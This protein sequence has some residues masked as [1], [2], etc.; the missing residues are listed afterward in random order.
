MSSVGTAIFYSR[1]RYRATFEL[2]AVFR[3][4]LRCLHRRFFHIF[5]RFL[6]RIL[7]RVR[8]ESSRQAGPAVGQMLLE[9]LVRGR[10]KPRERLRCW[11]LLRKVR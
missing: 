1:L 10:A 2:S 7:A 9:L 8:V 5:L 6:C 3:H 11:L 4:T